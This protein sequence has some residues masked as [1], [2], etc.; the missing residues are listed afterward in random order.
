MGTFLIVVG[1]IA[2]LGLCG[3][4]VMV[5]L[6]Q[7]SAQGAGLGGAIGGGAA[8]SAFGGEASTVLTKLTIYCAILFFVGCLGFSL[9]ILRQATPEDTDELEQLRGQGRPAVTVPDGEVLEIEGE[10]ESLETGNG[11]MVE[12]SETVIEETP[13]AESGFGVGEEEREGLRTTDEYEEDPG[14]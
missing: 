12:E 11:A 14:M 1:F 4:M 7:K 13:A 3:F 6:M 5:I 8:E 10:M 9:F 2:L